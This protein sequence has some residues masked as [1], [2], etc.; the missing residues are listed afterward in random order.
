MDSLTIAR[1]LQ[2]HV[3]VLNYA[4]VLVHAAIVLVFILVQFLFIK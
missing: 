2:K 1:A 4:S 3:P